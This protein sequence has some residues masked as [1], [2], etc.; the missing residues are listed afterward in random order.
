MRDA[1]KAVELLPACPG[2]R[3]WDVG[4]L[5]TLALVYAWTGERDRALET[6]STLVSSPGPLR[7]MPKLISSIPNK[8]NVRDDP[9]FGKILA[10]AP[11]T[12]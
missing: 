12:F 5:E 1:E 4:A 8:N 2:T 10:Q 7:T 11:K 9:R 6:I 3:W